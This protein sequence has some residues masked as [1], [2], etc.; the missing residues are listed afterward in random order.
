MSDTQTVTLPR[1]RPVPPSPTDPIWRP[2]SAPRA[3]VGP[4]DTLTARPAADSDR[5]PWLRVRFGLLAKIILFLAAVLV[6]LAGVTA[7]VSVDALRERMTEEFTSK[8]S[9]I[10]SSLASSSEDLIINRDASTVQAMVDRVP[11]IGPSVAYA[12]V[13]DPQRTLIAHTFAPLVPAG[14]IEQNVV[15]GDAKTQVR[16][17]QYAH[18]VT[19]A[20]HEIIDIG[21]PMLGGTLGTVRVGM[22][23]AI[24]N[25]AAAQATTRL[26]LVFASAAAVAVAAAVL[27]ARRITRPVSRLVR[28]AQRVGQGDLSETVP[29]TSG[30]EIGQ[31]SETFNQSIVRLRSLVQ[32]EA[33]RDEEKKKR[34]DLQR[35]I[36][37]F[38]D[39]VTEVSQGDLTKRGE[40]TSDVLGNVVDA[41]NVMVVE[42]GTII[43]DVRQAALRVSRGSHEMI[44]SAGQMA[45]G[46]Q[47]QSR[48][49]LSMA[50]AVEELTAS[51]RRVAEIAE[52]SAVAA[53]QA[54]EA[55]QKG[56]VAVRDSLE[57]MQRIRGEVQ[58]IAKKIKSLGDRSLEISAIVNTI[59]DIA[60]QTNL[61]ALNAAIEAAGAGEAGLRFAVVADEVRKLAERSAKA[62]K[63]IATLI[64]SV[65]AETH[66]AIVVMEQ[67]TQEVETGYRVTVQAG[68]SLKD[69][70]TISQKSAELAHEISRATQQQVRG[71]EGV[72]SAVQSIASVAVQT[73]QGVLKSRKTVDELA[74]LAEELTANLARFKLAAS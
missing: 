1:S 38:L 36:T 53:R 9:A 22:N 27:F 74:R 4:A 19:G 8:G 70:A 57:G 65:Q 42:I 69:I 34:E 71:A 63:D 61:L 52:A 55:S 3:R 58:S 67:G 62:T 14:L 29:V 44:A 50:G 32:T 13:Y 35:N 26:L 48:E 10:A 20:M 40:V 31:L 45:T 23:K 6:P 25:A 2:T 30:D 37:R 66:E 72:A 43:G 54:L 46:A 18:P 47:A 60:S 59:E 28:T 15:P 56:D 68:D 16:H 11:E 24:I 41:I 64:K 73:E 39:T 49:A 51:V 12:M 33:E 21:V 5:R 7:Y 17:V